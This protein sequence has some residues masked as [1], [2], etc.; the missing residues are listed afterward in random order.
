MSYGARVHA[1][2]RC[3]EA[4]GEERH[5]VGK[6]LAR[7]ERYQALMLDALGRLGLDCIDVGR[8]CSVGELVDTVLETVEAQTTVGRSSTG[9]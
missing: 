4:T 6:C 9:R 1:A 2:G 5:L 3:E 7:A 8:G